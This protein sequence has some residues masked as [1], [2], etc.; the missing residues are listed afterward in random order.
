MEA[1]KAAALKKER[2]R[3]IRS[4]SR[5]EKVERIPHF[6]MFQ[7]WQVFDSDT[8]CT[9]SEAMRDYDLMERIV[10]EHQE[11]YNFDFLVNKG[12]RNPFL[13]YEALECKSYDIDDEN[14]SINHVDQNYCE[15]DE[16]EEMASDYWKFIWEK[17]MAKKYDWWTD[18]ERAFDIVQN[19]INARNG[20]FA[21]SGRINKI[22]DEEYGLPSY[23][24]PVMPPSIPIEN[25]FSYIR[26]FKGMALDMRRAPEKLGKLLDTLEQMNFRPQLEA[27]KKLDPGMDM[28]VAWD[29]ATT[30]LCQ[31]FMNMK[32]WDMYYWPLFKQFIDVIEEKDCTFS[33][34]TEGAIMRFADY[35]N[36]YKKGTLT[37]MLEMDDPFEFRKTFPKCAIVGGMDNVLLGGGSKEECLDLAKKLCEELGGEGGYIM[38]QT[39]IGTF[40]ADG[41][42]ENVLAVCD[43]VRNYRC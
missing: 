2:L 6:S 4:A 7:L 17:G 16:L 27:I 15:Q 26:G 19:A 39:K 20:Y 22:C 5:W 40:R 12:V 43:Y 30:M 42:R 31:N 29:F 34:F 21:F 38:T 33:I 23:A 11:R 3:L 41:K 35:F 24:R 32:Q 9:L 37:F 1:E 10:R 13:I 14:E 36:D 18:P 25:I 8:H 28:S